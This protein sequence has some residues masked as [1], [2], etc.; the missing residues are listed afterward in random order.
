[1]IVE[2]PFHFAEK[3]KIPTR[4]QSD[5]GSLLIEFSKVQETKTL[6]LSYESDNGKKLKNKNNNV[7]L[8]QDSSSLLIKTQHK[9]TSVVALFIDMALLKSAFPK[10]ENKN[11]DYLF[12]FHYQ[13]IKTPDSMFAKIDYLLQTLKIKKTVFVFAKN[14]EIEKIQT[15]EQSSFYR[16]FIL[17]SPFY[18]ELDNKKAPILVP[19]FFF[20]PPSSFRG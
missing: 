15:L 18:A 6:S 7:I 3:N 16:Y 14:L 2:N 1:M 4:L 9:N 5:L 20:Q 17:D 13:P 10:L 19:V 12:L 8:E 11:I